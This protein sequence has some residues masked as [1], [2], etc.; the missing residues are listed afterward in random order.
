MIKKDDHN[1]DIYSFNIHDDGKISELTMVGFHGRIGADQTPARR[2]PVLVHKNRLAKIL[3]N[4]NK[5]AIVAVRKSDILDEEWLHGTKIDLGWPAILNNYVT[6]VHRKDVDCIIENASIENTRNEGVFFNFLQWYKS[7]N[8]R[9]DDLLTLRFGEFIV[10]YTDADASNRLRS[11]ISDIAR[12]QVVEAFRKKDN[13]GLKKKSFWLSRSAISK[14]D[15]LLAAVG[16]REAG[17]IY[18]KMMIDLVELNEHEQLKLINN[19]MDRLK[20]AANGEEK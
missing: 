16:L 3:S 15:I 11:Y 9:P 2:P 12:L 20:K 4:N 17:N 5:T 19:A 7:E 6:V 1:R 8:D 18:W 13:I 10:W 14:E